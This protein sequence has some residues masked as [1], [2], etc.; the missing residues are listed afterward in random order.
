MSEFE[1]LK[2]KKIAL[3]GGAGFIGHNLALRLQSLGASVEII[4]GMQVNNLLSLIDNVDN[5][6]LLQL[7]VSILIYSWVTPL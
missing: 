1:E 5:L 2:N 3:I 6:S 4:D 7:G